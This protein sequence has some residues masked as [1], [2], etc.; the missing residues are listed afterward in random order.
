VVQRTLIAPPRS[1]LGPVTAKER[2]V[3]Q[4]VSPFAGKYDT[5][6]NRESAA[7]VLAAKASDAAAAAQ[8]VEQQGTEAQ[9]AQARQSP[10]LWARAGTA[11]MAAVASSSGRLI[12]AELTGRTSRAS[13]VANAAGAV[14]QT[15]G[16]AIGGQVLGRFARGLLGGLLR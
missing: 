13:P 7:E 9:R 15:L 12:A 8:V 11:A 4:S 5:A 3:I 2:A 6:V 1:R 14:A 10:S 16:S